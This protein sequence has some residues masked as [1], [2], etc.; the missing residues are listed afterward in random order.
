MRYRH[1]SCPS[2][3]SSF[4]HI[5]TVPPAKAISGP[6]LHMEMEGTQRHKSHAVLNGQNILTIRNGKNILIAILS[7]VWLSERRMPDV[8]AGYK[9]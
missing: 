4:F 6:S 5:W 1:L 2:Y 7:I 8:K 3:I 9:H